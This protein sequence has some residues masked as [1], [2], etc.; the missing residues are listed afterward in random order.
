MAFETILTE[1]RDGVYVITL[2]RPERM[3]A[4]TYQMSEELADAVV[5]AN[6]DEDIGAI[7]MT[8]AGR[9]F[10]AGAD[11]EA[12]FKAQSEGS[13]ERSNRATSW[14]DLVRESKPFVA[15]VNGPAIGLGLTQILPMDFLIASDQAKLSCRFV[16]MGVVPELASSRFLFSRVGFGNASE[17]MMSG[18]TLSAEEALSLG[19]VDRVVPADE[20]LD[21]AVSVAAS[22]GQNPQ[23]ALRMIKE[24]ATLNAVETDLKAVQK[25]EGEALKVAYESPE[26]KEAIAAFL[27]KREPDFKKR[28]Q[29]VS[30]VELQRRET[31]DGGAWAEVVLNRPERRNAINGPLGL[32]LRDAVMAADADEATQLLLLRGA[33]GAFCSGLDLKAFNADPAPS[34][35]GDFQDIWRGAH[36]ALYTCRKPIV[37]ALERF[38]INGG[39]ALALAGDLLVVGE[40]AFLQIGEVQQGMAA[41]YNMAWLN[42]RV[43]EHVQAQLALVGRRFNGAELRRLGLATECVPDAEV[44]QV[45]EALCTRLADYPAGGAR[46]H[47]KRHAVD[48][49]DGR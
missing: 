6:E 41:P 23:V 30:A 46:A 31:P 43:A 11:V 40:E 36:S 14:V 49:D 39:A 17:M 32:E 13:M 15:A 25:R 5:E 16:R 8:G 34:W 3:N 44:L 1:R 29:L 9:G 20:L 22:M 26:H 37:V 24:L 18:R 12:V 19:L 48:A 2:N 47:Q 28:A 7:V 33:G 4:W 45:A 35:L 27:E 42:L 21:T 10:C 38:A